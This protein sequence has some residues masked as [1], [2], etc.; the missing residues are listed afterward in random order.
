MKFS[1]WL[2]QRKPISACGFPAAQP[3]MNFSVWLS[4]TANPYELQ[5]RRSPPVG[6]GRGR[7]NSDHTLGD[8]AGESVD[9]RM[10]PKP[11]PP[12]EEV[13][14]AMAS[15]DAEAGW[16]RAS[17]GLKGLNM[18][19]IEENVRLWLALDM[20]VGKAKMVKRKAVRWSL[21]SF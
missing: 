13:Q 7:E 1:V 19:A 6:G 14:A 11:N 5:R 4:R 18:P 8:L 16:E 17:R 21:G 15:L 12:F 9:F 3:N 10:G 2:S 20:L